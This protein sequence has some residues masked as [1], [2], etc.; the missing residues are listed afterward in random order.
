MFLSVEFGRS[1]P[2]SLLPP[3]LFKMFISGN[4]E[5]GNLAALHAKRTT[6]MPKDIQLVRRIKGE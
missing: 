6:F 5:D 3:I 1:L 2:E 4:F